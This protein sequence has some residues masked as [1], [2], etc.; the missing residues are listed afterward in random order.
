[1]NLRK[2][3]VVGV[4]CTN[5]GPQPDRSLKELIVAA[6]GQALADAGASPRQ[7]DAFYLGNFAG[8]MLAHQELNAA[9]AARALGLG[10]IPATKVEGAC[11]SGGI[12][13]RHGYLLIAT[14][15]ADA[16]LVAG[17]EKMS[18]ADTEEVTQAL[19]AAS[20]AD[21]G[22]GT[23]GMTFPGFFAAMSLRHAYEYGTT[24][25][26]LAAVAL[27]NRENAQRN[28]RAQFHGKS[29]TLEQI[30][31]SRLVA[32]PLRLFDCSPISDGAAA[33]VLVAED[34]ADR[35]RGAPVRILAAAQA[36]GNSAI[37]ET[38]DLTTIAAAVT[39]SR[40]AYRDAGI[41]APDVD[42]A[43]VHD[44]FSIAELIAIEDLG[45]C[46]KGQGGPFTAAG[47]TRVGGR[48]AVNTSGG[49]LSKGHPVGA[50]GLAQIFEITRQLRGEADNQVADAR[51]GLTHNVGGTG[52][53]CSVTLLGRM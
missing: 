41:G 22:E 28:P 43:E 50:T 49:L 52:G 53:V 10:E 3:T 40:Q 37:G 51:I 1:M 13:F 23:C 44:C 34:L 8:G 46:E 48:I 9:I 31:A 35:F 19:A 7:I 29:A 4:G 15:L 20:D 2:V 27:K 47:N 33:A 30:K 42:V 12:A 36:T 14:G 5:F 11:A 16:V 26:H 25:D 24:G 21:A 45:F 17:G 18:G 39:A 38:D 6:A 32:D